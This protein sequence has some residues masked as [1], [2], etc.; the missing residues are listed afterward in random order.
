MVGGGNKIFLESGE[1]HPDGVS[2]PRCM[3]PLEP[4]HLGRNDFEILNQTGFPFSRLCSVTCIALGNFG[5][6]NSLTL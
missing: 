3:L 5:R 4:A 2:T 6:P 1:K